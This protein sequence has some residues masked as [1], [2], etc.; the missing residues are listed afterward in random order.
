MK[1]SVADVEQI[2]RSQGNELVLAFTSPDLIREFCQYS[3]PALT[4][5]IEELSAEDLSSSAGLERW[6]EV[7]RRVWSEWSAERL[8]DESER[9]A[10]R[11]R[12]PSSCRRCGAAMTADPCG[13]GAR[14]PWVEA[15][16]RP[17][18]PGDIPQVPN[19]YPRGGRATPDRKPPSRGA[20]G[21]RK[22]RT[23]SPPGKAPDTGASAAS[24][25]EAIESGAWFVL[26][27]AGTTA[28]RGRG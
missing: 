8:E 25:S 16:I 1:A 21:R 9:E 24:L 15:P 2:W 14:P 13:C 28:S 10:R 18:K 5:A 22:R 6:L 20:A 11:A 23:G 4:A 27:H 17:I 26:P 3:V 12:N 7:T 19:P